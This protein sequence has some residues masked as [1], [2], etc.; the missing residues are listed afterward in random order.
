MRPQAEWPAVPSGRWEGP[1]QVGLE[2]ELDVRV[3]LLRRDN[4]GQTLSGSP[5]HSW[6]V[7]SNPCGPA[8]SGSEPRAKSASEF[9]RVVI[10]KLE[11][12]VPA[13]GRLS[14]ATRTMT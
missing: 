4:A 11:F 2:L 14:A 3:C 10:L 8:Y 9:N 1:P 6:Q 7:T 13:A 5:S 12:R